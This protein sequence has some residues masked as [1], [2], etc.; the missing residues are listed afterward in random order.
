MDSAAAETT[1]TTTTTNPGG[2]TPTIHSEEKEKDHRGTMGE[3]IME[4][5]GA[6]IIIITTIITEIKVEDL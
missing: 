2:R 3:T 4:E 5:I 6:I 1:E